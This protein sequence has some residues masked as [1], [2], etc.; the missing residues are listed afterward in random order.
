M[1]EVLAA[2]AVVAA[3]SGGPT[4]GVQGGPRV[5]PE[6]RKL[7]ADMVKAYRSLRSV[8]LETTYT[9]NPGGFTKPQR[10]TLTMRRPNRL[11]YEIW[12][13]VP[14]VSAT[15]CMRYQCGGKM[16]FIYNEAERYYTEERAPRD[17]KG[18]RLSGAGIEYA[19]MSGT[20]PFAGIEKQV[21]SARIEGMAEVEGAPADVVLLDTGTDQ[22]TG[23]ARFFISRADR[24]IRR[25][26]F[27]SVPIGEPPKAP[28]RERL[29]PDDPPEQELR[30]LPVRFG[31]ET[32][33]T[34]NAKIPDTVF[35]WTAPQDALLFKPLEHMLSPDPIHHRSRYTIVG[36]DGK[37]QKPLTYSDLIKK[38]KEQKRKR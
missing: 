8:Q 2:L 29:N 11:L 25:F 38:A 9:G 33:V 36:K 31:Y 21:R 22:R 6:A 7:L 28:V 20:D 16:L 14:G 15:S 13:G 32:K 12:Q 34:V 4:S 10:S 23:E 35:A 24:L 1:M 17:L 27:E 18:I 26:S 3:A 37:R 5:Q 30:Q 19:A